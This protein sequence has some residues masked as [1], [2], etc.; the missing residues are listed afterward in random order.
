MAEFAT[1]YETEPERTEEG[2]MKRAPGLGPD[3]I[4]ETFDRCA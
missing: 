4:A 3:S 2:G 1:R